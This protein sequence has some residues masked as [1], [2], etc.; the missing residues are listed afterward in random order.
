MSEGIESR[1]VWASAGQHR[2]GGVLAVFPA[3][4]MSASKSFIGTYCP[5]LTFATSFA[6]MGGR[7]DDRTTTWSRCDAGT[8]PEAA[9]GPGVTVICVETESV[10]KSVGRETPA[11]ENMGT[12][13]R[14]PAGGRTPSAVGRGRVTVR[15]GHGR[16]N[17][18]TTALTI[19]Q[20]RAMARG[21]WANA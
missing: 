15:Q 10:V 7:A 20:T 21:W 17:D 9:D 1:A 14:A 18:S 16:V 3:A 19:A 11:A 6:E 13:A 5:D 12:E 4:R 8:M 2:H